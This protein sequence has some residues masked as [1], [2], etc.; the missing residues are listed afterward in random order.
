MDGKKYY[1]SGGTLFAI[2]KENDIEYVFYSDSAYNK[3][4]SANLPESFGSGSNLL[5]FSNT[6]MID[7]TY[8]YCDTHN[9][10]SVCSINVHESSF[11][12]AKVLYD[13]QSFVQLMKD[14]P[15][16]SE[17]TDEQIDKLAI[18]FTKNMGNCVYGGDGFIYFIYKDF[19][20]SKESDPINFRV[21]CFA[22]D[23]SKIEMLSTIC[24]SDIAVKE[25][26]VYYYTDFDSHKLT[27]LCNHMTIISDYLFYVDDSKN[28]KS[29][30]Y[31]VKLDGTDA[32][33]VTDNE[34]CD[35]YI[36]VK[37]DSVYYWNK[38]DKGRYTFYKQSLSEKGESIL[39][40]LVYEDDNFD[41]AYKLFADGKY[42]YLAESDRFH[43]YYVMDK[44]TSEKGTYKVAG[45]RFD[46]NGK[47]LENL[48]CCAKA[49]IERDEV[50]NSE[51]LV[52]IEKI[53]PKWIKANGKTDDKGIISYQ[54]LGD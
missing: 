21:G 33:L 22:V 25:G 52:S 7:D 41:F 46:F 1:N 39:F 5:S 3:S 9:K 4:G 30:L 40:S 10:C 50:F 49:I 35:Y 34:C 31:R 16:M 6:V 37:S 43:S 51:S 45:Q 23:G 24:A 2:E 13:K 36:D 38:V 29:R 47:Y 17:Y 44:N 14:E 20:M 48:D 18:D 42:L 19:T 53:E 32:E 11:S 27:K 8:Y 26:H 28:G 12:N 54:C 15:Y